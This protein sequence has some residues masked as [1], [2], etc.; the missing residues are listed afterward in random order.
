MPGTVTVVLLSSEETR[1]TFVKLNFAFACRIVGIDLGTT[2]SCVAVMESNN[3]KVIENSEGK[4]TTVVAGL[5]EP[6]L[7]ARKVL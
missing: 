1:S 5:S 3:P 7:P 4:Y 2:N 6:S